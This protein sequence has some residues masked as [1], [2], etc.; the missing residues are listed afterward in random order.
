[1]LTEIDRD[2][3]CASHIN[4]EKTCPTFKECT[5]GS[6]GIIQCGSRH[7]K[8]PTPAQFKEEYGEDYPDDGTV[9]YRKPASAQFIA[10]W[11][12]SEWMYVR[13]TFIGYW[14][15]CA[16]TPRGKP[17]SE[18]RPEGEKMN[19]T[20]KDLLKSPFETRY[21]SD[22]VSFIDSKSQVFFSIHH[23]ETFSSE[24]IERIKMQSEF[25]K[26][27]LNEKYERDFG[28]PMQ[29]VKD[30]GYHYCPKCRTVFNDEKCKIT[31]LFEYCPS[32]GQKLLPPEGK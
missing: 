32:C 13:K 8:Y 22:S 23:P 2:Y 17:P 11:Q 24:F 26:D 9:Y 28:E 5:K 27:A 7:R 10:D 1:M 15:V 12:V 21:F 29:W 4:P 14:V 16:C 6:D 3:Y 19:P 31:P 30:S 20:L 18:W 25:I